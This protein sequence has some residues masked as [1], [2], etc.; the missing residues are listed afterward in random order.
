MIRH[1]R[2][3]INSSR[4]TKCQLLEE[5]KIEILFI[6]IWC[7][8]RFFAIIGG[9]FGCIQGV[10][11]TLFGVFFSGYMYINRMTPSAMTDPVIIFGTMTRGLSGMILG[12]F[13]GLVIGALVS[14][15][16]NLIASRFGGLYI[17]VAV[18]E[19]E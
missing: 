6:D 4:D 7:L 14:V 16:Y 11:F 17:D 15:I 3:N 13:F 1:P 8:S 19:K 12:L 2:Q 18:T 10:L 9:V 5:K